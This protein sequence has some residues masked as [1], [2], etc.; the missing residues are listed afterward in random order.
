MLFDSTFQLCSEGLL[1]PDFK[2]G[3]QA[4]VCKAVKV[5]SVEA[6]NAPF[7]F[8]FMLSLQQKAG[9]YI[10]RGFPNVLGDTFSQ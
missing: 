9:Y 2:K 1:E 3:R 7:L 10:M 8:L 6:F 4:N 5:W